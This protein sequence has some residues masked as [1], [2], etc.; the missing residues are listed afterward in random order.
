MR[1]YAEKKHTERRQT[2]CR[3][4]CLFVVMLRNFNYNS[5][6]FC[7]SLPTAVIDN[8]QRSL[9]NFAKTNTEYCLTWRRIN[10]YCAHWIIPNVSANCKS[11]DNSTSTWMFAEKTRS[12]EHH[13][14]LS[15]CIFDHNITDHRVSI[16]NWSYYF[17]NFYFCEIYRYFH[18]LYRSF[19]V[20]EKNDIICTTR[21]Y[22]IVSYYY[23]AHVHYTIID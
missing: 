12:T 14:H 7:G 19:F 23:N 20:V 2:H 5:R 6:F 8:L 3:N 22:L 16:I 21:N 15:R 1:P 9:R 10:A 4:S 13:K 18:L 17:Y 11:I